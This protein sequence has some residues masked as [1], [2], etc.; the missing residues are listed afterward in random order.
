MGFV[1][2]RP[3]VTP[4]NKKKKYIVHVEIVSPVLQSLH[5]GGLYEE[6]II[7]FYSFHANYYHDTQRR[8]YTHNIYR[9]F[10]CHKK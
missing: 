2:I 9:L 1:F 7:F 5:D 4:R 3:S 8:N 10:T 6:K